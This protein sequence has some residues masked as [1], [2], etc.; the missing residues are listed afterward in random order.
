MDECV[1]NTTLL[2]RL[3]RGYYEFSVPER[4]VADFV[5]EDPSSIPRKNLATITEG[6]GVI[7]PTVL[8]FCCSIGLDGYAHC[9]VE[10]AAALT[11]SGAACVHRDVSIDDDKAT[12]RTKLTQSSVNALTRLQESIDDAAATEAV[13]RISDA[14]RVQLFAVRPRRCTRPRCPTEVHAPGLSLRIPARRPIANHGVS[15][16]WARRRRAGSFLQRANKGRPTHGDDR[17]R[18]QCFRHCSRAARITRHE[19]TRSSDRGRSTRRHLFIC[20]DDIA[21]VSTGRNRPFDDVRGG[22]PRT[23]H[24][25]QAR[26][27]QVI[28]ERSVDRGAWPFEAATSIGITRERRTF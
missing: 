5:L 11:A 19:S 22:A 4:R 25:S 6:A 26:A 13:D 9:K 10:L 28:P 3:S 21:L 12:V 20:T 1:G 17:T 15:N 2:G 23:S 7:E 14:L 27:H 16:A 24:R 8:R 18:V